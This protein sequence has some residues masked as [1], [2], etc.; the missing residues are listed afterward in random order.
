M[1][2]LAITLV[3]CLSVVSA[4][5]AEQILF[6]F[7]P[8]SNPT[9]SPDSSLRYWNNQTAEYTPSVAQGLHNIIAG[10]VD[11]DGYEVP[12]LEVYQLNCWGTYAGG[13]VDNTVY[14]ATAQS[15]SLL[16]DGSHNVGLANAMQ[17]CIAGLDGY[18][19]DVTIFGSD[20]S[21]AG[22]SVCTFVVNGQE[23]EFDCGMNTDTT[24]T[25]PAVAVGDVTI[26]DKVMHDAILIKAYVAA[27]NTGCLGV[28]DLY[29]V[30]EPAMLSLIALGGVVTLSR[31]RR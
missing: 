1:K 6:D 21:S 25:F 16:V 18:S 19:Y 7:G 10:G 22:L 30:P 8:I 27:G 2:N 11:S 31:R 9:A 4:A 24:V 29:A 15:D 13:V 23:E 17:L 5:Q 20:N 14:P 12:G 3:A 28:V 26:G